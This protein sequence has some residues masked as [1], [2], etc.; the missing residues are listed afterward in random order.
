LEAGRGD[1][2]RL[3]KAGGDTQNL[4]PCV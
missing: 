2:A 1:D 3:Q 4:Y